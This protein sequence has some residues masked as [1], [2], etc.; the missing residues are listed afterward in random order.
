MICT[1]VQK[2]KTRDDKL[3]IFNKSYF[4]LKKEKIIISLTKSWFLYEPEFGR[5]I[6]SPVPGFLMVQ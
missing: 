5:F 6:E 2:K 3:L 1:D 4:Y